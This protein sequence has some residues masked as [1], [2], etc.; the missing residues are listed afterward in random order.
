MGYLE[1]CS[2]CGKKN[3]FGEMD[4]NTRFYCTACNAVHYE[5]PKPTATL[6]CMRGNQ[7]LLVR[8]AVDPGKGMWGLPGGF[9]ERGE[10]PEMGAHRELLEETNL[11]GEV[12]NFLGTCSHFNT[13]FGDI[14]LMGL[15]VCIKDWSSLKAGDDADEAKLFPISNLPQLAFPCH[16]KI[17]KIYKQK[18]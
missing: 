13:I 15:E 4:G 8:R 6:I 3:N 9:I 16:E 1:F 10:T 2:N 17:V 12:S 5:N 18:L 7:L 11:K 14:L